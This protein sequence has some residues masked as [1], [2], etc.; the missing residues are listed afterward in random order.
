MLYNK[1]SPVDSIRS[2]LRYN[3]DFFDD[4]S[5]WIHITIFNHTT[6]KRV[7]LSDINVYKD[8]FVASK[9]NTERSIDISE[10][11]SDLIKTIIDRT[12]FYRIPGVY[13]QIL[14]TQ[15]KKY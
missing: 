5:P 13:K 12:F 14:I 3:N 2:D 8:R 4:F 6:S 9:I 11:R 10:V 7:V 15:N 1:L